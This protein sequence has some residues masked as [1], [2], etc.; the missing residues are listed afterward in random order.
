M[1]HTLL[2]LDRPLVVFDCETTSLNTGD[3]R[4]VELGFQWFTSE[5]LQKEWRSLVNPEVHISAETSAIH[6]ITDELIHCCR[7]CGGVEKNL[8]GTR[9]T[10]DMFK[11]WPT[12][13]QLA[14]NLATG[15]TDVDYAG[16]NIRY[17]LRVLAAEMQRV[18]VTWTYAGARVIDADRLEQIGEP[19][20]LA[21]LY[22]KH[23]G[24]ILADAHQALDDVR[25]TTELITA[26]LRAYPTL[27]RSMDLLH[28]LQWPEWI[29]PEGKFRFVKGVPVCRFGKYNGMPM[30]H[31]PV[32]YWDWILSSDFSS[33][34]KALASNAKLKIFPQV[35]PQ[36]AQQ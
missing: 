14:A 16:K 6:G 28:E 7:V 5:G 8:L 11:P 9:C 17:D 24:K 13:K 18:K 1:I 2:H 35:R 36:E 29:D 3:A 25:A 26:Q 27:P 10:C 20:N 22:R 15:F 21:S 31:I 12:F 4:I 19:R 34:I 23:T 32:A 33:D 30:T